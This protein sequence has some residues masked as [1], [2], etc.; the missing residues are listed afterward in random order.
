MNFFQAQF[1]QA[2]GLTGQLPTSTKEELVFCGRSNVGKSS[3]INKLCNRKALARVS[4]TPGKTTTINFFSLGDDCVLVDLP[5][6]GYAKRSQNEK[7]RWARLMEHYFT[8]E[9]NISLVLLL[10]DSRHKPSA[11]DSTMLSFLHEMDI[12]FVVVLTKTDKLN[13]SEYAKQ[14]QYFRDVLKEY[15]AKDI[16]PFTVN[17]SERAEALRLKIVD[18]MIKGE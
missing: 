3:L 8:S 13:K 15:N 4:G 1:L 18:D 17:G 5:G 9:R 7:D 11:D 14:M 10:L 2:Y 12:P 6:Y 16:F